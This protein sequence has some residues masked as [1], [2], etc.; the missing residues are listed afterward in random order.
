MNMK[1]IFMGLIVSV[2]L[3]VSAQAEM[4]AQKVENFVKRFYVE[5][6][7]RTA[8]PLGLNDWTN[9]LTTQVSA[10][11]DVATGFVFSAE[12]I[13]KGTTDA[14]FVNT[15]YSAFFGRP[16]DVGGFDGW[17]E[18]LN[19]GTSRED[20]LNGFL[21]SSE[22]DALAKAAGIKTIPDGQ[23]GAAGGSAE[24]F[25]KRFYSE[26][27][28]RTADEAGLNDWT[29]KLYS[30]EATGS[31]I[32]VGFTSSAEFTSKTITD[33]E[34]V[35]IMYKAFFNRT[36]DEGGVNGW[37][38]Q[39]EG[40]TSRAAVVNGFLHS[41]E[42]INL[43]NGY[44]I[45]AFEGAPKYVL[46]KSVYVS[47]YENS[48]YDYDINTTNTY[49]AEGN[50]LTRRET[51]I[52]PTPTPMP[53][54]KTTTFTYDDNKNVIKVESPT[55]TVTHTYNANGKVLTTNSTNIDETNSF[56][57]TSATVITYHANGE[58][59]T[60]HYEWL[61]TGT[62]YSSGSVSDEIYDENGKLLSE[63]ETSDGVTHT[64]V[65]T[66]GA[67][68]QA[69]T[70]TVDGGTTY[71]Y[72]YDGVNHIITDPQANLYGE[73][74]VDVYH[75]TYNAQ[76]KKVTS[77]MTNVDRTISETFEYD[78]NANLIKE[79]YNYEGD[80]YSYSNSI[81]YDS[82]GNEISYVS[83]DYMSLTSYDPRGNSVIDRSL[84]AGVEDYIS[85]RSS[86][87][88][89]HNNLLTKTVDDKLTLT[90]EWMQIP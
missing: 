42:F 50:R 25:V 53:V 5:V 16:A 23:G 39:L 67:N 70:V 10:A 20:V 2:L 61:Y 38:G 82:F 77:T 54:D 64:A 8:E 59:A 79:T 76:G 27:L 68:G 1:K 37:L 63:S 12:Y 90:N 31:D 13:N 84:S 51:Y 80:N 44:H 24:D 43:C 19:A 21:Y 4:P 65:Y 14:E 22:F 6:L 48:T 86:T 66:I 46:V 71:T 55:L 78:A 26:V 85:Y 47:P 88:D 58:V 81:T 89:V 75:Y 69:A 40:G 56:T 45:I 29:S 11:S 83:G 15:L 9:K 17:I 28:G 3:S 57:D 87:Y 52:N 30:K 18:K 60:Y 32:A 33:L 72:E 74:S 62:D 34:F 73:V 49:D 41:E 35:N 36:G 7:G